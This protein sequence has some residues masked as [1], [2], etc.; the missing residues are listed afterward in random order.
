VSAAIAVVDALLPGAAQ[1]WRSATLMAAVIWLA[2]GA[3]RVDLVRPTAVEYEQDHAL[4]SAD[5]AINQALCGGPTKVSSQFRLPYEARDAAEFRDVPIRDVVAG[6]FGN[7]ERYCLTV[8]GPIVNNENGLMWVEEWIIR[9]SPGASLN[10]LAVR[11]HGLRLMVVALVS[12]AM[13]RLGSGP[14]ASGVVTFSALVALRQIGHLGL[15]AYPLD[16][17]LLLL[18]ATLVSLLSAGGVRVSARLGVICAFALGVLV[19]L[20]ANVR[21]SHLV[22]YAAVIGWAVAF[23]LVWH[24]RGASSRVRLLTAVSLAA[25]VISGDQVFQRLAINRRLPTDVAMSP[26]HSTWHAIVLS[27]A[28]PGNALAEREGIEW[29]DGAAWR[30]AQRF[31]PEVSYLS[32]EYESVLSAYYRS[33]WRRDPGSMWAV[34][35]L[36]ARTVGKQMIEVLRGNQG[37]DRRWFWWILR[38]LDLLPHGGYFLA[39]YIIVVGA[40]VLMSVVG[41]PGGMLVTTLSGIAVLMHL[42]SLAV[43]SLFLPHYHVYLMFYATAL[44]G[45]LWLFFAGAAWRPV[46]RRLV[47]ATVQ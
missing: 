28:T 10:D 1:P 18:C 3:A 29:S 11:L 19:A 14:L 41:H 26:H 13:I 7:I 20:G 8:G 35:G 4:L 15:T 46:R 43:T 38:P 39:L 12:V 23:A 37:P 40:G 33:L 34:Y 36:K 22:V 16:F 6:R 24:H 2:V 5:I 42:E 17:V 25:A 9:L 27:L 31:R 44:S 30:L 32:A 47:R 45:V 21:T